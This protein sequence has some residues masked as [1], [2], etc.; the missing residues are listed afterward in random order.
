MSDFVQ[1]SCVLVVCGEC[2]DGYEDDDIGQV[3]FD[4]KADA[5]SSITRMGWTVDGDSARCPACVLC[6]ECRQKGHVWDDWWPCRCGCA[7]GNPSVRDHVEPVQ[8]RTC[9]RCSDTRYSAPRGD[10]YE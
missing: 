6:D 2:K 3:Y 7:V 5:I 8:C 1:V 10:D 4:T 9:A